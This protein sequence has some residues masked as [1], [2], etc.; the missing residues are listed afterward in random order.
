MSFA[1]PTDA[2]EAL[3]SN[4]EKGESEHPGI[5][6]IRAELAEALGEVKTSR[7]AHRRFR[8]RTLTEAK[9]SARPSSKERHL[10]CPRRS[11]GRRRP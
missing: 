1:Q 10:N 3:T 7:N 8:S 4:S 11:G 9:G 2:W 5:V 6:P